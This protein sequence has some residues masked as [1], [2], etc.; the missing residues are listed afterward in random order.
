MLQRVRRW[1]SLA[2]AA[3]GLAGCYAPP[4]EPL[5]VLPGQGK[6]YQQFQADDSAC[7]PAAHVGSGV[8]L[9]SAA[10]PTTTVQPTAGQ[11]NGGPDLYA[12]ENLAYLQ[13]MAA[14][15][16]NVVPVPR[17]YPYP[18]Y[19]YGYTAYAP[20]AWGPAYWGWPGYYGLAVALSPWYGGWGWHGG[21]WNGG[22][23]GWRGGGW[24]GGWGGGGFRAGGWG[25]GWGGGGFRG[26]GW[27]G[28]GGFRGGGFGGG[29]RR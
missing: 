26:G 27:G 29:G 13:C 20:W 5:V 25:G 11:Q 2:G 3:I 1:A 7:R 17:A 9:G 24:N 23:G 8:G 12:Q 15:G 6:S 10:G 22:W 28:G 21:G 4:P 19:T 14:H 18:A 16:N